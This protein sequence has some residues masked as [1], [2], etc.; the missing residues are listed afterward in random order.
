MTP[1]ICRARCCC[2][3]VAMSSS[4][5]AV[6]AHYTSRAFAREC[7]ELAPPYLFRTFGK[8]LDLSSDPF[9][10]GFYSVLRVFSLSSRSPASVVQ[11]LDSVVLCSFLIL[12]LSP[13]R[14]RHPS[15]SLPFFPH[16]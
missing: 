16:L 1:G 10:V 14:G 9:F 13:E 5:A 2:V 3:A 4:S 8:F 11:Y 7:A 15:P 12:R 6:V